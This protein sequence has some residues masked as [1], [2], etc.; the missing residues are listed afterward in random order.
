M[1]ASYFRSSAWYIFNEATKSMCDGPSKGYV[2]NAFIMG[3]T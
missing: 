3:S 2:I 1:V